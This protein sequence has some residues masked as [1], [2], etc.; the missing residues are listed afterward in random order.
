M[1]PNDAVA[2]AATGLAALKTSRYADAAREL[3]TALR[4]Q[5][6]LPAAR[7]NLACAYARLGR[8]AEAEQELRQALVAKPSLTE[9]VAREPSLANLKLTTHENTGPTH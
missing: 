3:E 6:D 5:A 9:L 1:L 2:H 7:F 8:S 4:L